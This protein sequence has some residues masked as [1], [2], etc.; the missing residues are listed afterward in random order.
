MGKNKSSGNSTRSPIVSV[1]GHVD[2]GKSSV[3][4]AIR[5]T[6]ILATEAGAITQAIGASIIPLHTIQ[7]ISGEL[8]KQLGMEFTIPGLLFIDTPGHAAFTSL[9]KRGGAL[10]D[11]AILVVDIN[12]GFKP[13]TR[14]AIEILRASKTPFIVAANKLDLIPRF[15]HKKERVLGDIAAQDPL[16][17]AEVD[18]KLYQLVG[19]FHEEFG[20]QAERFD[21]VEDYTKQ[22][23]MVPVSA[24]KGWGIPELL[25]VLTGMAQRFLEDNL[26]VDVTG[27]AKGT[28][29][30]IKESKGLGTTIDAIIYDG[31]I[32]C[33]DT[34]VIGSTGEPI[35]A[36]VR[37]LLQPAPHAEMRDAKAKFQPCKEAMAA[38][39]VKISAPGLEEVIPGMPILVAS[40]ETLDECK[41]KVMAEV[42]SA[43][44][45]VEK[46]GIIIKA[47]TLGSLE[48]LHKLLE[49]AE[50]TVRKAAIGPISKKDIADAESNHEKDPLTSVILGFNIPE[51]KSTEKVKILINDVIYRLIEDF[52]E[53][54]EDTRKK[55]EASELG[56]LIRPCK[57]EILQ[58]CIFRMSNPAIVGVEINVGVLK[59]DTPVMKQDGT[60]LARVKAIQREKE[61]VTIVDKGL[62]VAIS[63]PGIQVERH[64]NEFDIL[65]SDIP[66]Q[67]FK[68]LKTLREYL[69]KE[70]KEVMKEVAILKRKQNP[71]WGV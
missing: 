31:V 62:Q 20:M 6:N 63:L 35:I 54:R 59:T 44:L 23:A 52:Q 19:L 58:N 3:L 8:L 2:H 30:E 32:K 25:M 10:A 22:L 37:A 18:K 40:S 65:L 48:A 26:N 45:N 41:Q 34:I 7:N 68:K 70:E 49:E 38:T 51:E 61:N 24:L 27:P 71:V 42:E 9:R 33:N 21:R 14:E 46:D 13:Q 64:I 47:D 60:R 57:M 56:N 12:E 55:M 28:V 39:G 17:A 53:W 29:L 5:G 1:L 11:I 67:D 36:K 50:I 43:L 66:E 15:K 16:V 4:D 69:S